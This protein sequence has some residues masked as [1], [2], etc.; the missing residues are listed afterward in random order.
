ML[1]STPAGKREVFR[2]RTL[3]IYLGLGPLVGSTLGLAAYFVVLGQA[4][5]RGEFVFDILGVVQITFLAYVIGI[6]LGVLPA[7]LSGLAAGFLHRSL[8]PVWRSLLIGG[9]LGALAAGPWLL[10][11]N[12]GQPLPSTVL[13]SFTVIGV[14]T[15]ALCAL[16]QRERS[17]PCAKG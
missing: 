10:A 13:L 2:W 5:T 7:L 11:I 6:V 3:W 9:L 12:G 14:L 15:G 8:E 1:P 4:A 17:A 16:I